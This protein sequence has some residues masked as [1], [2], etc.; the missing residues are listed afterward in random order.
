MSSFL[1]SEH[2]GIIVKLCVVLSLSAALSCGDPA[3]SSVGIQTYLY[4]PR[5]S[6]MRFTDN[7]G[8]DIGFWNFPPGKT[9][10][11]LFSYPNP[12]NPAVTFGFYLSN[13]AHV[14][15]WIV[16]ALGP[17][18]SDDVLVEWLEAGFIKPGGV[19]LAVVM[20]ENLSAGNYYVA[21]EAGDMP[22][23][24]YCYYLAAD[25]VL[26]SRQFM[27]LWRGNSGNPMDYMINNRPGSRNE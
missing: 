25:G 24:F 21:W 16:R 6:S 15:L 4:A 10:G 14:H 3:S 19:P 2:M 11:G 18:E 20:N 23:G 8:S 27:L 22:D 17:G 1:K 5:V 12:F 13:S 9:F 26:M 7:T